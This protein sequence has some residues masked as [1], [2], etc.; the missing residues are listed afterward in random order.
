MGIGNLRHDINVS[1]FS[2]FEY[3]S[4]YAN[5]GLGLSIITKVINAKNYIPMATIIWSGFLCQTSVDK[6]AKKF[7]KLIRTSSSSNGF[8]H[9][10]LNFI[11]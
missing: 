2:S 5:S 7:K 1:H 9:P 3:Q 8:F 10:D 6:V 11:I 4:N